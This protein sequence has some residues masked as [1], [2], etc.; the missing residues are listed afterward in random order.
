MFKFQLL[1][2]LD[3][4]GSDGVAGMRDRPAVMASVFLLIMFLSYGSEA[5]GKYSGEKKRL[6]PLRKLDCISKGK[7]K[8]ESS[9]FCVTKTRSS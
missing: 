6:F 8:K 5:K 7:R 9:H 2:P 3:R 1:V 4:N